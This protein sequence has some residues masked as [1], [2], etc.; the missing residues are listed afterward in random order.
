MRKI[1]L[2]TKKTVKKTLIKMAK[3]EISA[4]CPFIS[5]QPLVPDAVSKLKKN[6]K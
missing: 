5:Y 4:A 2:N 3:S 1:I 6:G